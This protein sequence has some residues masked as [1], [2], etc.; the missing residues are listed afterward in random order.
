V[1]WRR[2]TVR[3]P[4]AGATVRAFSPLF[5][6]RR[7]AAVGA[8]LPPTY[9]ESWAARHPALL[10]LLDRAERRLETRWPLYALSDHYLMELERR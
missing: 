9:A 6:R 1:A 7:L 2:L 10:R 3:Y 8:L 4:S 5:A